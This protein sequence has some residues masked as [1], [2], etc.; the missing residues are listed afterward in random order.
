MMVKVVISCMPQDNSSFVTCPLLSALE[1][2]KHWVEGALPFL[3][4]LHYLSQHKHLVSAG[5]SLSEPS[6]F[7]SEFG[8]HG[9]CQA[10]KQYAAINF[11]GQ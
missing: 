11:T 4:L 8:F 3:S 7:L 10:L 5:F 6:L 1:V 2:Y 9:C